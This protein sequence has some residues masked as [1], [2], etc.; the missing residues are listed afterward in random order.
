MLPQ[1]CTPGCVRDAVYVLSV[2]SVNAKRSPTGHSAQWKCSI[3]RR[4]VLWTTAKVSPPESSPPRLSKLFCPHRIVPSCQAWRSCGER[5]PKRV[6]DLEEESGSDLSGGFDGNGRQPMSHRTIASSAGRRG[7]AGGAHECCEVAGDRE[8]AG[9][10]ER[11]C[12]RALETAMCR[13]RG[14]TCSP[15]RDATLGSCPTRSQFRFGRPVERG[16]L[17]SKPPGLLTLF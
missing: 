12:G 14:R 1:A 8:H 3:G 17:I 4:R 5:T 16:S 13:A 7:A 11:R 9:D 15:W 2:G 10:T 6:A